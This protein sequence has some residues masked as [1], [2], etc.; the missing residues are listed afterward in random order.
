MS[1]E[2]NASESPSR[3]SRCSTLR[4]LEPALVMFAMGF[5]WLGVAFLSGWVADGLERPSM[6]HFLLC[7][8][9][10]VSGVGFIITSVIATCLTF[11]IT[12][13]NA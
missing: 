5:F 3:S 7:G 9:T 12:F 11:D 4:R 6:T 2:M 10:I 8:L 1:Q 13:K